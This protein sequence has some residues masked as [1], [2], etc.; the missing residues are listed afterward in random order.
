M[1]S[2]A[3]AWYVNA[4]SV[5]A[6]SENVLR[7]DINSDSTVSIDDAVLL[8]SYLLGKESLSNETYTIADLNNDS[9]VN[10]FDM[11]VLKRTILSNSAVP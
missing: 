8:Q 4:F 3:I 1:M 10:V 2:A 5:F 7:G 9:N 6:E 11:V